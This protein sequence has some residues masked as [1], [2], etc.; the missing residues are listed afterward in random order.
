M[1]RRRF[2]QESGLILAE[3]V[4]K[5]MAAPAVA[6]G[7]DVRRRWLMCLEKTAGPVL[8]ALSE[9]RLKQVMPVE[10]KPRQEAS[11]RQCTYLEALGRTICGI[12]PWL[13]SGSEVEL[14][15]RY[16]G[17][18]REAIAAGVD[19][20]QRTICRLDRLRRRWWTR[21]FWAW[22]FCAL[23]GS[24]RTSCLQQIRDRSEI[25]G[26]IWSHRV[27]PYLAMKPPDMG[28][29]NS[30]L[31]SE[32]E[33]DTARSGELDIDAGVFVGECVAGPGAGGDPLAFLEA[34]GAGCAFVGEPGDEL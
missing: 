26:V 4:P 20:G 2:L 17:L 11:R 18:A 24:W 22:G 9:R 27:A 25:T 1:D 3:G 21:R 15:G 34:A 28:H 8:T 10:C 31:S 12:A 16:C 23:R 7:G 19:P 30:W 14:R 32:V 13:E 33:L 29:P 6:S 5:L